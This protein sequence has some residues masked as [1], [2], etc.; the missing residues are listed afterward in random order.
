MTHYSN[1]TEVEPVQPKEPEHQPYNYLI[2]PGKVPVRLIVLSLNP[3]TDVH[4]P[5]IVK[6]M[7]GL[8]NSPLVMDPTIV[9]SVNHQFKIH[10]FDH[11]HYASYYME[12]SA[13]D[14]APVFIVQMLPPEMVTEMKSKM[15]FLRDQKY[16][17]SLN[18]PQSYEE[19]IFSKAMELSSSFGSRARYSPNRS[20]PLWDCAGGDKNRFKKHFYD[21][22]RSKL[23]SV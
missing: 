2:Y 6:L 13:S 7:E 18:K 16:Y 15:K 3:M 20:L 5:H 8:W 11:D 4:Y 22:R 9:K 12:E 1:G 19:G 17:L 23:K 10:G 21:L 14:D